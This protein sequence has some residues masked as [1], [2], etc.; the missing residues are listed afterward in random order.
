MRSRALRIEFNGKHNL[1]YE[2]IFQ[3][4]VVQ[5]NS[6]YKFWGSL[7]ANGITTDSGP[8][9]QIFDAFDIGKLFLST[10]NVVG[11]TG[12]SPQ[13]IEFKTRADTHLLI[14]RIARP[15]SAKLDNLIR[16]TVWIRASQPY[17]RK[18][19]RPC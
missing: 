8:R 10:E 3:Y 9:F 5:P 16:G 4:V 17:L 18:L 7:R 1:D 6:R 14:V 13:Q 2:N 19:S 15:P 11:T 12:W